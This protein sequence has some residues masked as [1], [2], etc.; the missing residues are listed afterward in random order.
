[1]LSVDAPSAAHGHDTEKIVNLK[2]VFSLVFASVFRS[3]HETPRLRFPKIV[4]PGLKV[5]LIRKISP[6]LP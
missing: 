4:S 2:V 5:F 3:F 1:M 6:A